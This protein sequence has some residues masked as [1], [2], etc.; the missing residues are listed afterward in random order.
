MSK[1]GIFFPCDIFFV[2]FASWQNRVHAETDGIRCIHI[3]C[4]VGH[5][6]LGQLKPQA[7]RTFRVDIGRQ[8]AAR[9]FRD[10]VFTPHLV[11]L[12]GQLL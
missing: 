6:A 11:A 12:C 1:T 9:A 8:V 7:V 4:E 3:E 10:A 5:L 2:F